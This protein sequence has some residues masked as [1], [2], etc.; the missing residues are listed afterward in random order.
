VVYEKVHSPTPPNA[1]PAALHTHSFIHWGGGVKL[2]SPLLLAQG[3]DGKQKKGRQM[4]KRKNPK[5]HVLLA[6]CLPPRPN[7]RVLCV[8]GEGRGG[9]DI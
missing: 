5:K 3:P 2:T 7:L 8:V 4:F 6:V 9:T 1:K